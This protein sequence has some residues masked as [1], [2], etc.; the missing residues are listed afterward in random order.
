VN[1][2]IG[3]S[4]F[5][6]GFA[7][8][9]STLGCVTVAARTV[10]QRRYAHLSG[11]PRVAALL[12]LELTDQWTAVGLIPVCAAGRQAGYVP[13]ARSTRLIVMVPVGS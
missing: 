12:L 6:F 7:R 10:V 9:A 8:L 11:A 2:A 13:V 1:G 4:E 3:G 5:A